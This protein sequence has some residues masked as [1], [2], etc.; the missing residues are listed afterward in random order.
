MAVWRPMS[1]RQSGVTLL[2]RESFAAVIDPHDRA[3]V[4]TEDDLIIQQV[5]QPTDRAALLAGT[6]I[7]R[8]VNNDEWPY[9]LLAPANGHVTVVPLRPF[10]PED[11]DV[12]QR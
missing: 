2:N 5:P 4:T 6:H 3:F 11:H 8:P 10:V 12:V 9:V 1:G 7:A